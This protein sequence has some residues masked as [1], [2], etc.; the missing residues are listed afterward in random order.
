MQTGL[1]AFLGEPAP[2]TLSFPVR[3]GT[4]APFA[5]EKVGS[6]PWIRHDADIYADNVRIRFLLWFAGL[7]LSVISTAWWLTASGK[8]KLKTR[9]MRGQ[10][11]VQ[12]RELVKLLEIFCYGR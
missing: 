9:Q 8:Q 1:F 11:V 3:G 4:S 6:L 7:A 10:K 5:V 2:Q 12:V